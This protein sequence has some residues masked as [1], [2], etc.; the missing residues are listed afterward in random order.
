MKIL[1]TLPFV[2]LSLSA[3][4][5]RA[6]PAPQSAGRSATA[7]ADFSKMPAAD[8]PLKAV[9][10][11]KAAKDKPQAAAEVLSEIRE[12]R[13]VLAAASAA[14]IA[15]AFP[16]TKDSAKGFLRHDKESKAPHGYGSPNG[17]GHGYG[18]GHGNGIGHGYGRGHGKGK[19]E[20]P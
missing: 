17:I 11:V 14:S 9:E 13:P 15:H 16:D 20:K 2:I 5:L 18:R 19:P 1:L 8:V 12:Q 10:K 7:Q 3:A 4:D 6:A